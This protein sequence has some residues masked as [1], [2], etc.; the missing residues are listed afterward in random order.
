[1]YCGSIKMTPS[2]VSTSRAYFSDDFGN[3][4]LVYNYDI[5]QINQTAFGYAS[6]FNDSICAINSALWSYQILGTGDNF[7][8]NYSF[9]SGGHVFL[10]NA[11]TPN[12][13]Y[14][15]YHI[16]TTPDSVYFC[17]RN[18]SS[19]NT[20]LKQFMNSVP[21]ASYISNPYLNENLCFINDSVG[22]IL[23]KHKGNL[24][25]TILIGT[26]NKGNTWSV[27]HTDSTNQITSYSF[28]SFN[29]GYLAKSNGVI[30]KTN[31]GGNNWI[32]INSPLS[33]S[34]SCIKFK[35]DTV[36]YIGSDN[37]YLAKT[38][39][40]GLSWAIEITNTTVM[41]KNIY[42]FDDVVYFKSN[43]LQDGLFKNS[44]KVI[45]VAEREVVEDQ[46]NVF[47]NP[48]NGIIELSL[49]SNLSYPISI[50]L[51]DVNGR[52]CLS[53][54]VD[55]YQSPIELDLRTSNSGVYF[56]IIKTEKLLLR[57]KLVL[58]K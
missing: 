2:S 52:I 42:L 40:A 6:S 48:T 49:K 41:V 21:S 47:P 46:L 38:V 12:Y 36:G 28:L 30:L 5:G 15:V 33:N 44:A 7:K 17:R 25:K 51:F 50:E 57:K 23:F 22:F 20:E 43:N 35:N 24:N 39:D 45:G 18:N 14:Y 55:H 4:E 9:G 16:N 53:K 10:T 1:M 54:S 56:V 32:N 8:T 11:V 26:A 37:G 29:K 31:D 34:I 13:L 19:G 27:M 58:M 3:M